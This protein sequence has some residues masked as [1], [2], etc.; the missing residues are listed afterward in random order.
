MDLSH[1]CILERKGKGH[2][3]TGA[4]GHICDLVLRSGGTSDSFPA[5]LL[6]FILMCSRSVSLCQ[7]FKN[8]ATVEKAYRIYILEESAALQSNAGVRKAFRV[9]ASV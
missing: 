6:T 4:R 1:S 7:F 3:G 9:L 5:I 2:C 8:F